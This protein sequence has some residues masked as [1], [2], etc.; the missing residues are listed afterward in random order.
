MYLD[1]GQAGSEEGHLPVILQGEVRLA[2]GASVQCST[3]MGGQTWAMVVDVGE[4]WIGD[5][6][7]L[8]VRVTVVLEPA[9]YP[10]TTTCTTSDGVTWSG[11]GTAVESE[12]LSYGG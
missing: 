1:T 5:R 6:H 12:F 11:S 2:E 4:G 8:F 7:P 10:Y 9:D 3:A